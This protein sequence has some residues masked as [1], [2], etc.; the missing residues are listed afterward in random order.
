MKRNMS[1][2][3]ENRKI[4]APICGSESTAATQS[5]KNIDIDFNVP[6]NQKNAREI[7]RCQDLIKM[8]KKEKNELLETIKTGEYT[9]SQKMLAS[10]AKHPVAMGFAYAGGGLFGLGGAAALLG[11]MYPPVLIGGLAVALTGVAIAGVAKGCIVN[12]DVK[13]LT[14]QDMQNYIQS[15]IDK[16]DEKIAYFNERIAQLQN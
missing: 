3:V 10:E 5:A 8:Y 13:N 2:T 15:E 1:I 12:G 4:N 11:F 9:E 14:E 7:Q 16:I 6:K